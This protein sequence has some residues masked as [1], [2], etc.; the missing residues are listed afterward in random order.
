MQYPGMDQTPT[1]APEF[2]VDEPGVT[3]HLSAPLRDALRNLETGEASEMD[4]AM[5][6]EVA[7]IVNALA[8]AGLLEFAYIPP[9]EIGGEDDVAVFGVSEAAVIE[10]APDV[11]SMFGYL[12]RATEPVPVLAYETDTDGD[13]PADAK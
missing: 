13:D 10:D 3:K 8:A 1:D 12:D 7:S 6:V 4:P 2:A 11:I 9:E 5:L